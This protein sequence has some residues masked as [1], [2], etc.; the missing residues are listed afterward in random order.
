MTL[1]DLEAILGRRRSR[2]VRGRGSRVARR[3][4]RRRA[5]ARGQ[6]LAHGAGEAD[7]RDARRG[8]EAARG[9]GGQRVRRTGRAGGRG[10]ARRARG[11]RRGVGAGRRAR[12]HARR[13]RPSARPPPPRHP[14]AARARGHLRRAWATAS[15]EGP[16]VEDDWHNFEALN[17]VPGHPARSMQDTLYVEL[18][19]PEQVMLRTHTSPVQIRTMETMAPP[20]YVV[21]PGPHLPQRDARRPP[22]AGVPPDRGARR[23]PRHHARRPVR[24][25]RGVRARAVRRRAASAPASAPTSSRTPSRRPSS[26]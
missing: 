21:A 10:P 24:H 6:G 15:L 13:P 25:H 7:D 17:M 11:A 3:A 18:G 23:R 14:G 22:L 20:I 4:R 12:P 19:E 9:Q 5:R 1:A 2:R 16:E 8:R 26:R